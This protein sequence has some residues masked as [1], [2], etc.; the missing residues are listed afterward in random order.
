MMSKLKKSMLERI[1]HAVSFEVIA[2]AITAPIGAWL[3]GRSILEMG[4][5]AIVLS[6]IAMLL[7]V[8]Y[9]MIFDH[10]WPLSKGPRSVGVRVTHAVGFEFSFVLV[11]LPIVAIMLNMTLW[12]AFMLELG[13]FAFFLFYTYAFNWIFDKLRERWF[14]RKAQAASMAATEK[15]N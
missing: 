6:T 11:G 12:D 7:N 10:F 2:I 15:L 3:L 9:N 4:S 5:V 14:E 8:I 1:L 13:F